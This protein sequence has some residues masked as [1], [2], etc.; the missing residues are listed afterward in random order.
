MEEPTWKGYSISV[1]QQALYSFNRIN[2]QALYRISYAS[3]W[4]LIEF[5]W[6]LLLLVSFILALPWVFP[7]GFLQID[8]D[9]Q[10]PMERGES[11]PCGRHIWNGG[12][13]ARL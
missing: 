2:G 4:I 12:L 3:R 10:A 6:Q 7:L 1:V 13:V 5:H 11:S 9:I 8:E